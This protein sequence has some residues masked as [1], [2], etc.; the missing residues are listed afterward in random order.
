MTRG[1]FS[2]PGQIELAEMA[3]LPPFAQV[4]A[5]MDGLGSFGARRGRGWV[6]G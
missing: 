6:H 1:N 5:N 4:I 3:T 2:I